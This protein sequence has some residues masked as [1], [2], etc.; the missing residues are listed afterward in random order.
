M[1]LSPKVSQHSLVRSLH[2]NDNSAK[3]WTNLGSLYLQYND[4]QLANEAFTKAQSADP[5]YA[6]AWLGQGILATLFGNATEA[7]GLLMHA[8]DIAKSSSMPAQRLFSVSAFDHL[9]KSPSCIT[10]SNGSSA[11]TACITAAAY[12]VA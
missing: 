4:Y 10:R 8:F 6:H 9:T 7:R 11:T 5:E 12:A 1:T 2:L 3:V